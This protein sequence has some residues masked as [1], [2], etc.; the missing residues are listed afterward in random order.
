MAADQLKLSDMAWKYIFPASFLLA[1]CLRALPGMAEEGPVAVEVPAP[2]VETGLMGYLVPR[3]SLKTGVRLRL[4]EQ[5]GAVVIGSE[6][7]PVMQGLGAVWSVAHDDSPDAARF[8]DWLGSEVGQRTIASYAPDGGAAPFG[9]PPEVGTAARTRVFEGDATLGLEISELHCKR[10]H[11]VSPGARF[12]DIGSTPSFFVL[13]TLEDWPERFAAFFALN[14]HPA[15]TQVAD[16]TE[17]FPENRPP[18]IA[19]IEMTMEEV[20]AVLAYV[21][22]LE[23]ADLGGALVHQ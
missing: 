3:F 13:R 19:P 14:P 21:A 17:P 5:G 7:R 20:E 4:V 8:A 10:C 2:I 11:A 22:G 9:P 16:V 15:F 12:S 23:A 18:P 6:G 1:L